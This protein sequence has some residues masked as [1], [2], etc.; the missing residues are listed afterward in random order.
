MI[1]RRQRVYLLLAS[2]IVF[3]IAPTANAGFYNGQKLKQESDAAE[4]VNAGRGDI[5][6]GMNA[7]RWQGY[8]AGVHDSYDGIMFCTPRTATLAQ[9]AEVVRQYLIRNPAKW[10]QAGSLLTIQ[11]LQDAFPCKR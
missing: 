2:L 3:L 11:A 6:D 7:A 9:I 10:N 1:K 8:I 4:R 5:N